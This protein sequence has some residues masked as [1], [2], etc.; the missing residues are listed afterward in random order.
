MNIATF[1]E[2]EIDRRMCTGAKTDE[3][4]TFI[5]IRELYVVTWA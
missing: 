2:S 3:V 5:G 1:L 4:A